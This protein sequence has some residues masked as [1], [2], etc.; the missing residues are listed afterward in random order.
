M[1]KTSREEIL[2]ILSSADQ[3]AFGICYDTM[4]FS[5]LKTRR[6][7]E[8]MAA[9]VCLRKDFGWKGNL[10]VRAVESASGELLLYYDSAPEEESHVYSQIIEFSDLD[11]LL[12]SRSVFFRDPDLCAEI[13]CWKGKYYLWYEF[14]TSPARFDSLT[15]TL[16]EFGVAS[17]VDRTFLTEHA[18]PLPEAVPLFLN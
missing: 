2:V 14:Y 12:D 8:Q 11:G 13:Y 4:S 15:L 9:L 18:T 10:S 16:L 5:D 17:S 3:Q 1:E 7:C 6:F